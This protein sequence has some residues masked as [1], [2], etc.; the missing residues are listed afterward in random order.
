MSP[1][2]TKFISMLVD[3]R[4]IKNRG[5]PHESYESK[6]NVSIWD[7]PFLVPLTTPRRYY[8]EV[9]VSLF[10]PK[11]RRISRRESKFCRGHSQN[12]RYFPQWTNS[13]SYAPLVKVEGKITLLI[14][15]LF[16]RG[17]DESELQLK[18]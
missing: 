15:I 6:Q 11:L 4:Y 17:I 14:H 2:Q 16:Y 8:Y 12:H 9:F 3:S 5:N 18:D 10:T 13:N 1:H 7:S